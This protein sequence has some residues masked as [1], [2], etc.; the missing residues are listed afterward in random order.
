M[1]LGTSTGPISPVSLVPPAR[2]PSPRA[3][4]RSGDAVISW[5]V[6][7]FAT[8][9]ISAGL[10]GSGIARPFP[11]TAAIVL[12][13]LASA[14]RLFGIQLPGKGFASFLVGA[15]PVTVVALGWPAG[16][17][18]TAI[19]A[20][21]GDT[22]WRRAPI[23][24]ALSLAGHFATATVLGGLA[25]VAAGGVHG[26]DA[27][28]ATNIGPAIVLLLV[29]AASVNATYFIQVK[30]SRAL[31]WVDPYLT[32]R[33]ESVA[34]AWSALMF[35]VALRLLYVDLGAGAATVLWIAWF[36]FAWMGYWLMRK[37][38]YA[39]SLAIV[40]RLT[41]AIGA[42]TEFLQAFD[43]VKQLTGSLVPWSQMGIAAY[44]ADS[45]AFSV[46]SDTS[47]EEQTG[48]SLTIAGLN[49]AKLAR[50]TAHGATIIAAQ[51]SR[52]IVPLRHGERLVGIWSVRHDTA[53]MYRQSDA[54]LLAHLAPQLG[55]SLAL[56]ALIGPV[57]EAT[58]R[59]VPQIQAITATTRVLRATADQSAAGARGMAETVRAVAEALAQGAEQSEATRK[60]AEASVEQGKQMLDAGEKMVL[61]ARTV[62]TAT[63]G[64]MA[65]LSAAAE[66]VAEGTKEVANLRTI[67]MAVERFRVTITEMADQSDLL[68]LNTAIEAG[69][70]GDSA[71]GFSVIAFEMRALAEKSKREADGLQSSVRSIGATVD[72]TIELLER[73]SKR[74]EKVAGSG[75][76][77]VS[78][79]DQ[80]VSVAE[81]VARTGERIT[82]TAQASA[83]DSAA[84]VA[85]L[86]AAQGDAARAA[87]ESDAAAA[88][89]LLGSQS[90]EALSSA[91]MELSAVA[92]QLGAA[93]AAARSS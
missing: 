18:V 41:R 37:G 21:S 73:T 65:Q 87:R 70:A 12:G 55:L 81:A 2:V 79:L 66:V 83:R 36:G 57:L 6:V 93:A 77:L 86:T 15:A 67:S 22:L 53:R 85:T 8:T 46:V 11:W 52:I 16:A 44:H 56:D 43:D 20:F 3:A 84:M 29:T 80:I 17:L 10:V 33:W 63:A 51:G 82:D 5:G 14:T 31:A 78:E 76:A 23:A 27:F 72:R 19:G 58:E 48:Q 75:A 42:R 32:L 61:T 40:Q 64:A 39:E 26:V 62:R 45:Q 92:E 50:D 49:A 47:P 88:A 4:R 60:S 7:V 24:N 89:S 1:T 13:V 35:G 91:T 59:T 69:R 25:Y 54:E 90:I 34:T 38:V 71:R 68:A 74:V 9:A 28:S 30:L